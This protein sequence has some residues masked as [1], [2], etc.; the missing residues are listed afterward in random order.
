MKD[1]FLSN[2]KSIW[3]IVLLVSS[4]LYLWLN[5]ERV[6]SSPAEFDKVVVIIFVLVVF[7]PLVRE[8][9]FAGISIKRELD[10]VKNEL[11]SE[12]LKVK[13]DLQQLS[14]KSTQNSDIKIN[15]GRDDL[16]SKKI[17]EK[18]LLETKAYEETQENNI[19]ESISKN[20]IE[21][22]KSRFLIEE[23]FSY[24]I[25][26]YEVKSNRNLKMMSKALLREKLINRRTYEYISKVLAI[27]NRG[28]HGEI[29]D[30]Q[31]VNYVKRIL[32]EILESL[33]TIRFKEMENTFHEC[34]K[35]G[36]NMISDFENKC[37]EC[38]NVLDL[39]K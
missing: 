4:L 31:Y 8:L 35:C 22:F 18:D 17:I 37:P 11:K 39:I 2:R 3:W 16:P 32:P 12:V 34:R 27:C 26:K 21:L 33:S 28:I 1:W 7:M 38:G 10:V 36:F 30:Q 25:S 5:K 19:Y 14:M 29:V 6:I 24:I 20:T 9:S 23:K 13:L 15:I